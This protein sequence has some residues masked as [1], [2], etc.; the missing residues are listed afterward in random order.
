MVR[1]RQLIL[2]GILG[3]AVLITGNVFAQDTQN[4]SFQS[5][6]ADYYLQKESDGS[7]TMSVNETLTANF[8]DTDQNHG[9]LRAIPKVYDGHSVNLSGLSV[10]QDGRPAEYT[11]KTQNDNLALK[12][13][14]AGTYVHGA[15]T[16]KINYTLHDVVKFFPDHDEL[17]WDINGDQWQQNFTAVNA[18]FHIPADLAKSLQVRQVCYKGNSGSTAQNC[19]ITRADV[20]DEFIVSSSAANVGPNQTLSI[21][22]GFQ[23]GTFK[24]SQTIL[25]EQQ[26]HKVELISAFALAIILPLGA[27]VFMFGRWRKFGNDPKGRGVIIPEYEP[28]KGFNPLS[29]DFMLNEELRNQAFSAS[30]IDMAVTGYIT[31]I[32]IPKS[33]LFSKKDYELKLDRTPDQS[34]PQEMQKVLTMLFGAEPA[35]GGSVRIS[36]FRKNTSKQMEML[37]Q[38]RALED[39]LAINLTIL[40]YFKKNPKDVKKS[41]TVWGILL[42][43]V[44][45]GIYWFSANA[46]QLPASPFIGLGVGATISSIVIFIFSFIMP[47][48]T[49]AGV[50]IHDDLLGLKDYIKLA[51]ADRLKFLQSPEGAEKL[52]LADQF[53]PKTLEA[54][55][56]LFE[57]LLPYAMLFGLE[58]DW[59]KQFEGIYVNPPGWYQGGNWSAFSTG[60][61]IGSLSDFNTASAAS[62]A[63]PS[64]SSG[65][66][67]GGGAGGGGGGGGGGGW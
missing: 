44:A 17:F 52:P 63:A 37:T 21:V 19:T 56:K 46:S 1:L 66:G 51:E 61:L 36:E 30:I 31:I 47:A 42:F 28:P 6:G 23:P 65:S 60:Y 64:S 53:D 3:F 5:F 54:K 49:E 27:L 20:G 15:V 57:K 26:K 9:I 55:V 33:G 8:P 34:L 25:K 67:F 59:A 43:F 62:F 11:Q 40:G 14:D 41:Y 18:R 38:M 16:Y 4:F 2:V 35:A 24:P 45:W 7:A 10:T 13:G 48:R 12:I 39:S 58:K 32:E 29:S 22:L 50:Q